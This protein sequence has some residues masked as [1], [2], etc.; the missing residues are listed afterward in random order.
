MHLCQHA[1]NKSLLPAG[2]NPTVQNYQFQI[3]LNDTT[4]GSNFDWNN[5]CTDIMFVN[6]SNVMKS[7]IG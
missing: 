6:S 4:V 2:S 3:L 5:G 1:N 7:P